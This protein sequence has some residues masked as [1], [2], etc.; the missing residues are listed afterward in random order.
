MSEHKKDSPYSIEVRGVGWKR[1]RVTV[2]T[3]QYDWNCNKVYQNKTLAEFF[4]KR[5][6]GRWIAKRTWEPA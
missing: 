6:A 4:T 1:Y 3:V 5:G 2:R